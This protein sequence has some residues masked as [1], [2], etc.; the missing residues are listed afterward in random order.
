MVILRGNR[1]Q[2]VTKWREM[3]T[4]AQTDRIR[5]TGEILIVQLFDKCMST[6]HMW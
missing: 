6:Y 1:A 2:S 4:A 5:P 3:A